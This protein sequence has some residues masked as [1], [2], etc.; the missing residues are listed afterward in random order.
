M[1]APVLFALSLLFAS[2]A[3]AFAP[4]ERSATGAAAEWLPAEHVLMHTP[5]E[6]LFV[7]VLHP[8]AALFEAA[9]SV[10][11]AA[12]EHRRYVA[13]LRQ[14]AHVHPWLRCC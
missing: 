10:D 7:G 12:A 9:F 8:E 11:E 6:E 3:V 1:F 5:G 14:G 2:G 4:G 13:A